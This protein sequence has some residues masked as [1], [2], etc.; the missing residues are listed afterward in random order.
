MCE[1]KEDDEILQEQQIQIKRLLVCKTKH[2]G[3][4]G[5]DGWINGFRL[6]R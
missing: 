2:V 5:N 1:F 3:K 6:G 4:N